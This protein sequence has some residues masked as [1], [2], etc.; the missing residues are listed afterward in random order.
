MFMTFTYLI[1]CVMYFELARSR[2]DRMQAAFRAF[3]CAC[4]PP[5]SLLLHRPLVF[6]G[7]IVFVFLKISNFA[8]MIILVHRRYDHYTK[9][10]QRNL[11]KIDNAKNENNFTLF[12][13]TL[14]FTFCLTICRSRGNRNCHFCTLPAGKIS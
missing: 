4:E 5:S 8:K 7:F 13:L 1:L 9:T 11:A 10:V 12:P 14:H 2:C 6:L 3:A